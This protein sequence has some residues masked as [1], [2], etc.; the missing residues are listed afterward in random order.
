MLLLLL[1]LLLLRACVRACAAACV[2]DI[3]YQLIYSPAQTQAWRTEFSY[4]NIRPCPELVLLTVPNI[5]EYFYTKIRFSTPAL[6][7]L[8][9]L[10]GQICQT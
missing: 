9:T 10:T 1:L 4:R 3:M 7:A 2:I 5:R 6:S 8:L